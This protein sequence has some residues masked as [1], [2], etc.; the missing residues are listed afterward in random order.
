MRSPLQG[1]I[2][3]CS[4]VGRNVFFYGTAISPNLNLV[5]PE[6]RGE[7]LLQFGIDALNALFPKE[8]YAALSLQKMCIVFL[9]H[10][11]RICPGIPD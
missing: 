10:A 5:F 11:Y 4:V 7:L 2:L 3:S 8:R 1:L 6:L 9:F